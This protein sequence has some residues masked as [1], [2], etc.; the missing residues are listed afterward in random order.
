MF[1]LFDEDVDILFE[2]VFVFEFLAV[3]VFIEF[4]FSD[5][6]ESFVGKVDACL[7][8]NVFPAFFVDFMQSVLLECVFCDFVF[9]AFS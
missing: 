8:G 3:D 1:E 9:V 2:F 4:A 6:F 5:L 7:F